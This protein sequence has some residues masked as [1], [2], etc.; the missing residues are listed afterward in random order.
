MQNSRIAVRAGSDSI[1]K[2]MIVTSRIK[3]HGD[4]SVRVKILHLHFA[5]AARTIIQSAVK[6]QSSS[7]NIITFIGTVRESNLFL[8]DTHLEITSTKTSRR[9]NEKAKFSYFDFPLGK[10]ERTEN[11]KR[12]ESFQNKWFLHLDLTT[13]LWRL[14]RMQST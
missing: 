1:S 4:T 6:L 12:T 3:T 14:T 8:S 9:I 11:Y 7:K 13:H 2:Q 10:N 5:R